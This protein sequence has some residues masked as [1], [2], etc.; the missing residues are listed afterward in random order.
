MAAIGYAQ[1]ISR[2]SLAVRPLAKAAEIS[3]SVNRRVDSA[4]RVP[5]PRGVAIE[6]TLVGHREF[7]LRHEGVNLELFDAVFEH[8]PGGGCAGPVAASRPFCGFTGC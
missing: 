8:L 7:A 6:D 5:F 2:L 3:G 4:D 1:L